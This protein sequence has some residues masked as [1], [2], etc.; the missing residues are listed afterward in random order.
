VVIVFSDPECEPC[1]ELFPS[2]TAIP[3]QS[4]PAI[5]MIGRGDAARN[6]EMV[7]KHGL[8][9]PVGLQR[10]WEVSREYGIFAAPAAFLIDEW[11]VV[12]EEVAVGVEAV[13]ALASRVAREG[14]DGSSES[15]EAGVG[16]G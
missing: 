1:E 7:S 10:H 12:E 14:R 11:G 8:R 9:F 13:L 15:H 5:I 6:E 16:N 2:L 3:E 4:E